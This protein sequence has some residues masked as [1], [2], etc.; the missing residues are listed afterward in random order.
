[1]R[2]GVS[3]DDSLAWAVGFGWKEN[4]PIN[5]FGLTATRAIGH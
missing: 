4:L 5:T 2:S 3:S 1:M